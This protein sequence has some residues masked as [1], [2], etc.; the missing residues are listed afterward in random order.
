MATSSVSSGRLLTRAKG[1]DKPQLSCDFCRRRKL[2]CD[3]KQPCQSCIR[4]GQASACSFPFSQRSHSPTSDSGNSINQSRFQERVNHLEALVR[5]LAERQQ[6]K[7][8]VSTPDSTVTSNT[9]ITTEE[10]STTASDFGLMV[11]QKNTS[12]YVE[13]DHWTAILEEINDLKDMAKEEAAHGHDSSEEEVQRLPGADLFFLN[14]YPATKMEL[15]AALPARPTVDSM[16]AKYFKAADMPITLI[17]HRRVF[18][19]QYE[20]FWQD[21]IGTPTMWMTILFGMMFI[22]A[23]TAL[24][25]NAGENPLDEDTLLEYQSIVLTYRE[26]MIQCLRLANYMKGTPHTIEALLT[27]LLTEYAQGEEAQQGCWQLIGTIIRVALKMGYHRDGS[28]FPEMKPFEAEMRRRTWYVLIQ[29][30][31]AT[32]S[33]V[34]LPR[35]IKES[36]C[37]TAEP[38]NLLDDD[39]DDTITVLP[40]ARPFNEH[41]LSQFLIYKSRIVT[42]YGMICDFTTSSKQRDYAEAT[43]LD[44][45]L[46]A[47]FTQKPPVLEIKPL[48][49]S[50]MDGTELI[51]RRLYIAM[52]FY[53]ASMTLHRKFMILAKSNDKYTASHTTC[54]DAAYAALQLQAELFEHTQ[55]GRMLYADRWKIFALIQAEFL[56]ATI[57]LCYNLD[58]DITQSRQGT[59]SL[60]TS[61]VLEKIIAALQSAREIWGKQQD[62]SKEA[63]TAVKAIN[64]VLAKT[65]TRADRNLVPASGTI[66]V[67]MYPKSG[68]PLDVVQTKEMPVT[69]PMPVFVG[70]TPKNLVSE[71]SSMVSQQGQLGEGM[72]NEFFDLDQEWDTWMQF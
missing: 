42:V 59:S 61:E 18:F 3:R 35:M 1:R 15:I 49:R 37:D 63:R 9:S 26:K 6:E 23:Y 57:I 33:Q 62:V 66:P 25:I 51:T 21:P 2:R 44:A 41:T 48:H 8:P 40:P 64:A 45:L 16:I 27:L 24:Y 13:S 34:G 46:R 4:L 72:W 60:C 20:K 43:R 19:T 22:V 11:L 17:I 55:P 28:H 58:D 54:L 65:H 30:D 31:I 32:A 14:T 52:S 71:E 50:I 12:S 68:S 47:A 38:R 53:H 36:Q 69:T 56:L 70:P 10:G 7:P 29:F 67:W 39:F 5:M